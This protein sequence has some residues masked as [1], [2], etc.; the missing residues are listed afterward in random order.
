M[1]ILA[2]GP[3][4]RTGADRLLAEATFRFN[5]A[6]SVGALVTVVVWKSELSILWASASTALLVCAVGILV[7]Q[8]ASRVAQANEVIAQAL[9]V[10]IIES[11]A[12]KEATVRS[13]SEAQRL[14]V[15]SEPRGEAE[16]VAAGP[17]RQGLE[18]RTCGLRASCY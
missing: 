5:I 8:V 1:G 11:A 3:A 4:W 18:P 10:G 12:L 2:A 9:I 14:D 6:P 16:P 7:R 17:R 15:L 13:P